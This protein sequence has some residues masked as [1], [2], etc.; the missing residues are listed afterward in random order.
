LDAAHEGT[1]GDLDRLHPFGQFNPE[2]VFGTRGVVIEHS[3]EVFKKHHF[4]FQL[5]SASGRRVF[6]V[7]WNM[8]ES[9]PPV[10]QPVDIAYQ[11][12]WNR[13]NG[14]SF[15]QLQLQDW[16]ESG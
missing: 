13:F 16:R 4:R 6:G 1:L 15:V 5:L 2:P 11:L 3:P 8:G 7:A 9:V 14:R 12:V 10:G